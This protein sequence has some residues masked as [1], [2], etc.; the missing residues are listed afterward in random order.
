LWIVDFQNEFKKKIEPQGSRGLS[1]E[2]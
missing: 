2:R 1:R